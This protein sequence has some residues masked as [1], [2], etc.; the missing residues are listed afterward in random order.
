MMIESMVY[1]M[2]AAS[3]SSYNCYFILTHDVY[4]C[5]ISILNSCLSLNV[6]D[7]T[8]FSNNKKYCI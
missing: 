7:A 5:M 8:A 4:M 6:L 2:V 1:L 3:E